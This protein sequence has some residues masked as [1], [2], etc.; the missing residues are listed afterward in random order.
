MDLGVV[1]ALISSL[2]DLSL[3]PDYCFTGEVGLS[4]EV[5]AVSKIEQRIQEAARLGFKRIY[6]S[7][8]NTK[9]LNR[10]QFDIEI[11]ETG[12]VSDLYDQLFS[13]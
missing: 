12:R 1:A 5:R 9:G 10:A 11:A 7:K 3:P 4:G 13:H 8:Y 6:I 2:E